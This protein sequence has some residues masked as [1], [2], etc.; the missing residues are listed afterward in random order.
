MGRNRDQRENFVRHHSDKE[1]Y[2]SEDARD[3]DTLYDHYSLIAAEGQKPLRVDKFLSNLLPFTTRS[4][5]KNASSTGSI[6]VNGQ[7][8][9]VSYKV[10]AGDK[11][12]L[13]LPF[14][15]TPKLEA[16]AMDLD[17]R[18]ED[19]DFLI[20]HKPAAMVC[21]PSFGHRTGTLVHGL[22]HHFEHL[23]VAK[24]SEHARPGLVHRLDRDTT[25]ILVIAKKE[26]AMAHLSKQFF[27]RTTDRLYQAI[28]WG[29]VEED[30]GTIEGH[31]GRHPKDRKLYFNYQ[32]GE[33]GKH[34]VTHYKVLER[35]GLATLVQ[36][37]LE[38]GRTHQIRV[39][40]KYLGHTLFSD[41]EY[42]GNT[43][44]RGPNTK[45]YQQFMA[46]CF[47]ICP[48]QALHAKYLALDHP[49]TGERME[50]HTD[51]PDDMQGLIEKLRGN[52][53]T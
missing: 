9:K 35:F 18:Y 40:M 38:T 33:I 5:I 23:P 12:K 11:V 27:D 32:D 17:I 8:V 47:S 25:G 36:C 41:R 46:N 44:Q 53:F 49:I 16:E 15:P 34:A 7:E 28:V 14:P 1:L 13:M 52:P 39:H 26:Y 21:H 6:S 29:N 51:L 42:G 3:D 45:K 48:R 10:K 31:I 22:L 4:R 50:F 37:K 2:N 24:G 20:V 30:E 19:D 43:I